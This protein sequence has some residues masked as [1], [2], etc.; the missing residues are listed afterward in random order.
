MPSN[1]LIPLLILFIVVA[2]L[3][4]ILFVTWSIMMAVKMQTKQEMEKKNVMMSRDGLKVGIKELNDEKYKDISQS[5]L[6][7]IWNHSTFPAYKR[8]WWNNG[9]SNN[10]NNSGNGK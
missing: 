2:F 4:V 8:R 9:F 10:N 7:N 5:V 1:R 6:V 3:A